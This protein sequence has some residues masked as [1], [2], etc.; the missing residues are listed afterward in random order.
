MAFSQEEQ[1]V[2]EPRELA[3][4]FYHEVL[5]AKRLEALDEL[6]AEDF[7]EHGRPPVHGLDGFRSFVGGLLGALPDFEFRVHDWIEQGDRVVARCEAMG[8]HRGELFGFP[9]TGKLVT[10]TAIHIWRGAD[11]RLV[12]RWSEADVLGIIEQ[13]KPS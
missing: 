7:V 10:W 2:G 11:G 5:N 1:V 12:E 3:A 4:R 13:L 8:T 6:I 9:A